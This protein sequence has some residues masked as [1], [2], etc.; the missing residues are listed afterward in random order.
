MTSDANLRMTVAL[1]RR[2]LS[3][4]CFFLVAPLAAIV[5]CSARAQDDYPIRAMIDGTIDGSD[6][7]EGTNFSSLDGS[8]LFWQETITKLGTKYIRLHFAE[9]QNPSSEYF[10]LTIK[11]SRGDIVVKYSHETLPDV[12]FWTPMIVGQ[13]ALIQVRAT[14]VPQALTFKLD[15]VAYQTS[16]GW[17]KS[18]I[19]DP[20]FEPIIGYRD[21]PEITRAAMAVA[22]LTYFDGDFKSCTGFLIGRNRMMTNHHCIS[23]QEVCETAMAIFGFQEDEQG[24]VQIGEQYAC[25]NVVKQD[26]NHDYAVLELRNDP[27]DEWGSLE[28]TTTPLTIG[29]G[30]YI[31]QHPDG[32][33]KQISKT[34]CRVLDVEVDGRAANTDFT[35]ECD[36]LG[37]S[38]GSPVMTVDHKVIGLHHYGINQETYWDRNRAV[39]SQLILEHLAQ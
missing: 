28:F 35:H 18:I 26:Y 16:G 10:E 9:F 17:W 33:P 30:I 36:T 14:T 32:G 4:R 8:D 21:D 24:N 29:Q 15:K 31:V 22:K 2:F 19:G 20:E 6:V 3:F 11:N 12:D 7:V 37:G 39:R 13:D 1:L 27:G 25:E 34:N 23:R 38:S 5:S